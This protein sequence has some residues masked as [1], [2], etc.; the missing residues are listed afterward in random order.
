MKSAKIEQTAIIAV[1]N[2][3]GGSG[4]SITATNLAR[5]ASRLGYEVLL[6]DLDKQGSSS[7]NLHKS[8]SPEAPPPEPTV[9]SY[10]L[11]SGAATVSEGSFRTQNIDVL[12]GQPELVALDA[13]YEIISLRDKM[14]ERLHRAILQPDTNRNYDVVVIDSYDIQAC[15][16]I[17]TSLATHI[18]IPI[19][20]L[21]EN[22]GLATTIAN[23]LFWK[24][25]GLIKTD[26][27]LF[28][29][30]SMIGSTKGLA[31]H[32]RAIVD[33]VIADSPV[34]LTEL[35]AVPRLTIIEEAMNSGYDL[36]APTTEKQALDPNYVPS[37]LYEQILSTLIAHTIAKKVPA[38]AAK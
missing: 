33:S 10:D 4:K 22:K 8:L 24:E 23:I 12:Y 28:C 36:P 31:E 20:K 21:S 13:Q 38:G 6:I 34:P 19:K 2:Q 14:I 16:K 32:E 7:G 17:A 35:P 1:A 18:V 29:L 30:P 15:A 5:A 3:K 11:L 26:P 9:G 27:E 25:K 37:P